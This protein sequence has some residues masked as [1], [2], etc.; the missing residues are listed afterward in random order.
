MASD[1]AYYRYTYGVAW[2]VSAC[3]ALMSM[4]L[5]HSMTVRQL[6]YCGTVAVTVR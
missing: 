5:C 3:R 6:W 4:I 1:C 2:P